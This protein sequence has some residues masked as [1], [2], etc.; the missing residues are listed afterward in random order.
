MSINKTKTE[1]IFVFC[2]LKNNTFFLNNRASSMSLIVC[3]YCVGHQFLL[4]PVINSGYSYVFVMALVGNM[5]Y[6][7]KMTITVNVKN[8]SLQTESWSYDTVFN[9]VCRTVH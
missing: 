3:S 5:I 7:I 8:L 1:F 9:R 6:V 2:L 4:A